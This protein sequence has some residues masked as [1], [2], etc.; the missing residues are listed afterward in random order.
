MSLQLHSVLV[1]SP[2]PASLAAF[3]GRLL[4]LEVV[5]GDQSWYLE[6]PPNGTRM[7][8]RLAPA[9]EAGNLSLE[10]TGASG[11]RLR[12]PVDELIA[13]GAVLVLDRRAPLA[14]W[15]TLAD[16]DGNEFLVL[17]SEEELRA[18]FAMVQE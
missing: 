5:E 1:G 14:G 2:T 11:E 4:D 16:P 12:E 9:R 8:F 10:L 15:A 18:A 13:K 7:V 3:W 17:A 6:I